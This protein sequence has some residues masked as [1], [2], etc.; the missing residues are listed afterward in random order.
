MW[1]SAN[2]CML[3]LSDDLIQMIGELI[4]SFLSPQCYTALM[5]Q[6]GSRRQDKSENMVEKTTQNS[7]VCTAACNP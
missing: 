5:A 3:Q 6:R 2:A 4:V 7:S 1:S